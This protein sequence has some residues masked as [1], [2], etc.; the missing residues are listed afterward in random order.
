MQTTNFWTDHSPRP[1]DLLTHSLPSQTDVAIVGSGYTGLHAALALAKAGASVAVLEQETIG[2]GASSRNG[3]MLTAG[4]KAS[5][6]D[7]VRMYG[8]ERARQFWQ[9]SLDSIDHVDKTVAEEQIECDFSRPGHV[10]LA[11][12]PSHFEHFKT[13]VEWKRDQFGYTGGRVVSPSDLRTEIGSDAYFGGLVDDFSAGLQPAKYVFGLAKAVARRGVCLVEHAGVNAVKREGAG[14]R[15]STA[16]GEITAREVL[17]ATNGYT[18][19]L[20]PGVRSGIFPVGS[21]IIATE[22]LPLDLQD[23]LSPKNRVFFDSKNFL[24]YFRL[25]PDGRMLFGGRN[26]LSTSLDLHESARL[27]QARML[28][29]YPQLKG[30]SITHAWT[31]KLGITFDLMPHV[32]RMDGIHYAY[33]YNGHGV[34]IASY[35]GKEV[36][37]LLAGQRS[38][39]PFMEIKHPRSFIANFDRLYLPFVGAWYRVLDRIS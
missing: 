6:K 3:G 10:E 1:A 7:I 24:N 30:I 9:W 18:T 25:T 21:Y 8:I 36:G 19:G 23:E 14:F 31:G 32:G 12:K 29:V 34:S 38:S 26:D 28:E 39:V 4:L 16:K 5:L 33:G 27:L 15:L 17:L 13:Y 35:L 20:V 22:P 37:E 11:Y 2:F